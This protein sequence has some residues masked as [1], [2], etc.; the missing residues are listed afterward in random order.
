VQDEASSLVWGMPGSVAKAGLAHQ[1]LPLDEI[2]A[3]IVAEVELSTHGAPSSPAP[4]ASSA[5]G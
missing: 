3:A 5:G 2:G 4:R 1:V